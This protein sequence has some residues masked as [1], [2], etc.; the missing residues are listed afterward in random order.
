MKDELCLVE[1][2]SNFKIT[3]SLLQSVKGSYTRYQA[4]LEA[5]KKVK[6][7]QERKKKEEEQ[8]EQEKEEQVEKEKTKSKLN[9]DISFTKDCIKQLESTLSEANQDILNALKAPVFV[10]ERI[11]KAHPLIDMSLE[12]KRNLEKTLNE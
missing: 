10:K 8:K 2:L 12:R 3:R 9:Q 5:E 11:V 7:D 4:Y 6:V 1:G